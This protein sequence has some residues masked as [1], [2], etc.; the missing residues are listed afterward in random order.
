MKK[1]CF[2]IASVVF[3]VFGCGDGEEQDLPSELD[4]GSTVVLDAE[5]SDAQFDF[6]QDVS[7]M[8]MDSDLT[9]MDE[10]EIIEVT[11][12]V[13]DL[14]SCHDLCGDQGLVCSPT[15]NFLGVV[16]AGTAVYGM[17]TTYTSRCE[18]VPDPHSATPNGTEPLST[19][20][21]NCAAE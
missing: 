4:M 10:V 16:V 13:E 20:T 7:E 8:D 15:E 6:D 9:E 18:R 1:L 21:C 17:L 12:G 14:A 2:C 11:V 19:Y 3:L 5:H